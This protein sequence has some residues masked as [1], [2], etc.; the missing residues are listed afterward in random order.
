MVQLGN[1]KDADCTDSGGNCADPYAFVD[2]WLNADDKVATC[3]FRWQKVCGISAIDIEA[4]TGTEQQ[5]LKSD[6]DKRRHTP[7]ILCCL[8]P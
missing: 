1:N 8:S 4:G 2:F 5:C 3:K 7:V 6:C